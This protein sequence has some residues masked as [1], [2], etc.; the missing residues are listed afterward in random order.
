MKENL[1]DINLGRF[2][3]LATTNKLYVNGLYL[4]EKNEIL[5]DYIGGEFKMIES[6][7]NAET[8]Q[9]TNV[10]I[11]RV[12]QVEI[13]N[14]A[15]HVD[16]DSEVVF[17][18]G[19]LYKLYP[20]KPNEVSRSDNGKGTNFKNGVVEYTGNNCYIPT[21]GSCFIKCKIY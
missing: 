9:K 15:I 14:N 2:F 12:D 18:P 17:I 3:D 1:T 10:G 19:W 21:S 8:E 6:M 5:M 7:L 11:G 4:H 16:Y 13:Y 20:P